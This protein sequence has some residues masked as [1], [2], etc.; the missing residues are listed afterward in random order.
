MSNEMKVKETVTVNQVEEQ[1]LPY[2]TDDIIIDQ[3]IHLLLKYQYMS[4]ELAEDIL[5]RT[6]LQMKNMS[7]SKIVANYLQGI[8]NPK[9]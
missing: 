9:V 8:D 7:Y 1:L 3:I 2:D 5:T 4:C 6:I